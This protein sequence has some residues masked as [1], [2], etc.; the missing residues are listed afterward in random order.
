MSRRDFG[1]AATAAEQAE[2]AR[3]EREAAGPEPEG[4]PEPAR[5]EAAPAGAGRGPGAGQAAVEY[6]TSSDAAESVSI[7]ML[8]TF[9]GLLV[10]GGW[11]G[12]GRD[13]VHSAVG[14]S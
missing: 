7:A 11:F 14:K 12:K 10:A 3:R 2:L 13:W 4:E 9:L 1:G 5:Q 6:G 8:I